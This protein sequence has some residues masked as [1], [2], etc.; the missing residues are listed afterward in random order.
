MDVTQPIRQSFADEHVI[1]IEGRELLAPVQADA[2]TT[3]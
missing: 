3:T 2:L 1:G